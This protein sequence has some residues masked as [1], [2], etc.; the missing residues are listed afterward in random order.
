MTESVRFSASSKHNNNQFMRLNKSHSSCIVVGMGRTQHTM[1]LCH[2]SDCD[3]SA[4][5]RNIRESVRGHNL[6]GPHFQS[7]LWGLL[8]FLSSQP[9]IRHR[10]RDLLQLQIH[11][12]QHS[13]IYQY[14]F[15]CSYAMNVGCLFLLVK[16]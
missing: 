14:D 6:P 16:N 10:H 12:R 9:E 13:C 7:L 4:F 2:F 1:C 3:T 8:L 15:L 5:R 11:K